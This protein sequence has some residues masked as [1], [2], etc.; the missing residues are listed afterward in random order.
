MTQD[1]EPE[2]KCVYAKLE[3]PGE[4]DTLYLC[5]Y[6]LPPWVWLMGYRSCSKDDRKICPL[7]QKTVERT[8]CID[9]GISKDFKFKKEK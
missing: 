3:Y 5:N 8:R 9:P 6:P 1:Q 4:C 7:I 2:L